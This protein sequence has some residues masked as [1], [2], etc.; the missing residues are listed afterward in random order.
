MEKAN[1]ELASSIREHLAQIKIREHFATIKKDEMAPY[2]NCQNVLKEK[3]MLLN[4]IL[5]CYRT[6]YL[7][8]KSSGK[9]IHSSVPG[10]T[11]GT[12]LSD[13]SSV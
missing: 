11:L 13:F 1:E 3:Y 12:L 7:C 10:K 6:I 9:H 5:R 8:R 2:V 4:N